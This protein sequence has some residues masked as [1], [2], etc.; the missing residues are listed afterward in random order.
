VSVNGAPAGAFTAAPEWGAHRLHAGRAL[1][2][3]DLNDVVL[4]GGGATVWIDALQLTRAGATDGRE[5]G[6]EAR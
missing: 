3:R 6:F 1:W 4:D 2:R 5:R